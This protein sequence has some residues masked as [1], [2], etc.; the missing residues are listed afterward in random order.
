MKKIFLLITVGLIVIYS[1]KQ[2]PQE[3]ETMFENGYSGYL[4]IK[5]SCTQPEFIAEESVGIIIDSD[6]ELVSEPATLTYAGE[7]V[8][9]GG[10]SKMRREGSITFDPYGDCSSAGSGNFTINLYENAS[11]TEDMK[12]WVWDGDSWELYVEEN[13]IPI[14]WNGGLAFSLNNALTESGDTVGMQVS[15]G[16]VQFKLNLVENDTPTL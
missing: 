12:L 10:Q 1:C 2:E 14:N 15:T 11:G 3:Q 4:H 5:I 6:G 8:M 13:D 7:S 9:E 16:T